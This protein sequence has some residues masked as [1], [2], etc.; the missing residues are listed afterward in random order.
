MDM[1]R[2]GRTQYAVGQGGFHVGEIEDTAGGTRFTYAY[3]C[4][5]ST[6]N[7]V[8]TR[9]IL[10]AQEEY[11]SG[12]GERDTPNLVVLSHVDSDHVN[13]LQRLLKG[14][15][16]HPELI[17]IPLLDAAD[18]LMQIGAVQNPTPFER[19]LVVDPVGALRP[20]ADRVLQVG[21]PGATNSDG[22]DTQPLNDGPRSMSIPDAPAGV[23]PNDSTIR[24]KF[25]HGSGAL[26]WVFLVFTPRAAPT[27]QAKFLKALAGEL[28][29]SE[30]DLDSRLSSAEGI[31][32]LLNN[33][34]GKVR[35]AT[36]SA[37]R[38]LGGPNATSLIMYSGLDPRASG[39][40]PAPWSFHAHSGLCRCHTYVITPRSSRENRIGW[41]HTG[42][43]PLNQRAMFDAFRNSLADTTHLV[44][45]LVLP[46]HGSKN[47]FNWGLVDQWTPHT[48][49]ACSGPRIGWNH[50]NQEIWAKL[51]DHVC[52]R[53]H[54]T[55]YEASRYTEQGGF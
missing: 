43:A 30:E 16:T 14:R 28:Q 53:A 51:A 15:T 22:P 23:L 29:C 19:S 36:K 1:V 40:G 48:V 31:E 7:G 47:G 32:Q 44:G 35:N 3:D 37:M 2:F 8:L 52:E 49:V 33:S 17:L 24:L 26:D 21:A 12:S 18:R 6:A 39:K 11:L 45:T 27:L 46:H 10:L 34:M 25:G 38:G 41:I 5:G 13:G 55:R 9:E 50:P 4:G 20:F 42:D 54:V